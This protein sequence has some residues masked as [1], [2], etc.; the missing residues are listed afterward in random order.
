MTEIS[1]ANSLAAWLEQ[2]PPEFACS[3]GAR[4]ALRMTPILGSALYADQAARR[5]RIVL[6]SF[7][8]LAAASFGG[9]WPGRFVEMRQAARSAARSAEDAMSETFNEGQMNVIDSVEVVPEEYRYIHEMKADA[10]ALGV[11]LSA[12]DVIAKAVQATADMIDASNGIASSDAVLESVI[13]AGNAGHSAVDGANGYEELHS[14]PEDDNDENPT[15]PRHIYDFWKAVEGDARFL[16]AST[17]QEGPTAAPVDG[18]QKM[19]LWL[20][21]IPVWASRQ[22]A[23]FKDDLPDEEGW[24]VWVDWYEAR[25]AGRPGDA[26]LELAR[27]TI[28]EEDWEKGPAHVNAMIDGMI[29]GQSEPITLAISHGFEQLEETEE[30]VDLASHAARIRRA[31]PD[32][33]SQVIGATKEMLEATMK[34]ILHRRGCE[35]KGTISFP[36]LVERCF[37]E[38]DIANVSD[39]TAIADR[40]VQEVAKAAK[41]M[42]LAANKL[43]NRAGTGHGRVVGQEPS[44]ANTDAALVASTGMVLAAWLLR[45][46]DQV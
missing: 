27:V 39:A 18:L 25:W 45:H 26:G 2:R 31:L 20:D 13:A 36:N 46:G 5:G 33:P 11:A 16:E 1:D 41:E 29:K 40:P 35:V 12:V 32:D 43:R 30:I 7:R 38:L 4:I 34:T 21:G 19:S 14:E 10:N 23:L 24:N 6:P 3:L 37:S 44:V 17:V 9:A 15:T 22:W 8:A 28:G 42:L